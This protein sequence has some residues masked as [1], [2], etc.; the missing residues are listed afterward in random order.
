VKGLFRK[1][2]YS[3][4]VATLLAL[5]CT[6]PP[7]LPVTIDA[8]AIWVALGER[9]LPQGACTS[10]ATTNLVCRRLDR[11]LAGLAKRFGYSYTRY[12]DGLTFSGDGHAGVELLLRGTRSNLKADGFAEHPQKTR[13]MRSGRRY[14]VTGDVV[15]AKT[16]IAREEARELRAILHNAGKHGLASQNRAAHPNFEAHLRGRVGWVHML[17]P[18]KGKKLRAALDRALQVG[19]VPQ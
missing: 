3:E 7:R 6:E 2:G 10:P 12:A 9:M 11:R 15:N 8:Q 1:I 18:E 13:I 14:E 17:D 19:N 4:H 5:V 16:S